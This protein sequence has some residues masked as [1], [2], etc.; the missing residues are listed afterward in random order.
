ML[1]IKIAI[2]DDDKIIRDELTTITRDYFTKSNRT[3]LCKE[4]ESGERLLKAKI[5]FDII[6]LDI[7][8]PVLNGIETAKKLRNWDVNSKIIY[9]TN[10]NNYQGVAYKVRAFDYISKPIVEKAIYHVLSDAIHYIDNRYVPAEFLFKTKQDIV[11]VEVDDIY[12]FEYA[13]RKV[14]MVTAKGTYISSSY[15]LKEI[16]EKTYRHNFASPH[17]S[18][19]VNMLHIKRI[20]GFHV[21]VDNDICIPLAQKRAV[22]FKRKYNDFLQSTVDII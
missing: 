4:F 15:S 10:H 19:I 9:V 17:K 8:M 7:E 12:Y 3:I 11:K 13:V 6:F 18:Y 2:C 14:T 1:V 22:D 5:K 16:Y 21:F 20:K